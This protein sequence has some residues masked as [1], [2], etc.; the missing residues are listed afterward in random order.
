[1]TY[2]I[3]KNANGDKTIVNNTVTNAAGTPFVVA[4]DVN[5]SDGNPFT[6]FTDSVDVVPRLNFITTVNRLFVATGTLYDQ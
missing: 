5:D 3:A 6:I 1:M 2:A 4:N